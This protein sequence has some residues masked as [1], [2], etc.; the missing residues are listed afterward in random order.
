MGQFN[1]V[2]GFYSCLSFL[3]LQ[4]W[5]VN[6]SFLG[7]YPLSSNVQPSFD[8]IPFTERVHSWDLL[9]HYFVN[10]RPVFWYQGSYVSSGMDF[11]ISGNLSSLFLCDVHTGI[12]HLF[13]MVTHSIPHITLLLTF[14]GVGFHSCR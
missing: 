6:K 2:V 1:C 14:T 13:F 10:V 11:T 7:K 4:K 3:F 12:H 5:D 9:F 8:P